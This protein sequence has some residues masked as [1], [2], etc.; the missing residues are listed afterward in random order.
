[1]IGFDYV[2][3]SDTM[4]SSRE[5]ITVVNWLNDNF[6]GPGERWK[7]SIDKV[8]IRDPEDAV[9][10]KLRFGDVLRDLNGFP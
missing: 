10:F 4:P 7:V 8:F 3:G 6:G 1:M 2:F 9:L 5:A